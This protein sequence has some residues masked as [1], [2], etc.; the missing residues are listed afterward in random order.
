MSSPEGVEV[1]AMAMIGS[2]H[3]KAGEPAFGRFSLQNNW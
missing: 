3:R 1:N 2:D